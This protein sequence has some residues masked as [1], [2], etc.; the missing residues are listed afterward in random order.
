MSWYYAGRSL[1]AETIAWQALVNGAGGGFAGD[2]VSIADALVTQMKTRSYYSK[3]VYLLPY[4]GTG[5]DAARCPLI[6]TLGVAAAT[7]NSLTNSHFAQGTGLTGTGAAGMYLDSLVT[8]GA[9]NATTPGGGLGMGV[10]SWTNG[11]G[12][13]CPMGTADTSDHR[14]A[15][16][17]SSSAC[18]LL[19]GFTADANAFVGTFPTGA[20]DGRWYGQWTSNVLRKFWVNGTLVTT[21]TVADGGSS[22][23][24]GRT[25]KILATQTGDGGGAIEPADLV[26]TYAVMTSGDLSTTE[27]GDLDSDLL[28]YLITP[29]GR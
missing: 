29:T 13:D 21:S 22:N 9:L 11:T 18:S 23:Y 6:N 24:T 19:W 20:S 26:S 27:G 4:L 17:G 3:V 1:Q 12:G 10:K 14:Y 16:F 15:L 5:I 7:K 25:I 8:P 28:N 2:S